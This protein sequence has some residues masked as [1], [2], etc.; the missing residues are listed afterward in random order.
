MRRV[1]RRSTEAR[2]AG[3]ALSSMRD[4]EIQLPIGRT[5]RFGLPAR[6]C[7]RACGRRLGGCGSDE[8]EGRNSRPLRQ[9][10][11][12]P[13][14][15]RLRPQDLACRHAHLVVRP[16]AG[17]PGARL[18]GEGRTRVAEGAPADQAERKIRLGA[19]RSRRPLPHSLLDPDPQGAQ[20]R[21]GLPRGQTRQALPC[22]RREV[23]DAH[24]R[25]SGGAVRARPPELIAGV[26]RVLGPA[27][28]GPVERAAGV[29]GRER[30]RRHSWAGRRQLPGPAR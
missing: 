15:A 16:G 8:G 26:R 5:G 20:A 22:G 3:P 14:R 11:Y 6:R 27:A 23:F 30:P 17:P 13:D 21:G 4:E 29:R 24:A 28:D 2:Q 7:E 10:R 9:A 25:R 18:D 19:A 1:P 12:G